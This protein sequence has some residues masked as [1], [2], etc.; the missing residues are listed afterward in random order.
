MCIWLQA[1]EQGGVRQD[2]TTAPS[3]CLDALKSL[4]AHLFLGSGIVPR[5]VRVVPFPAPT[6]GN[7]C[8]K[9]CRLWWTDR[10]ERN[11]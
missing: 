2:K 4:S 3:R 5:H 7:P 11:G 9:Q 8:F 10:G 1:E 6:L